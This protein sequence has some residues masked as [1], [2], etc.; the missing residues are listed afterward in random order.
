MNYKKRTYKKLTYKKRNYKKE[1]IPLAGSAVSAG[2]VAV[3]LCAGWL[4]STQLVPICCTCPWLVLLL[5]R[6]YVCCV[7]RCCGFSGFG[8][9][10]LVLLLHWCSCCVFRCGMCCWHVLLLLLF[11][12]CM[13]MLC[14]WFWH[15]CLQYMDHRLI[16]PR[17]AMLIVFII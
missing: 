10:I 16:I 5:Y 2:N 9:Y 7:C 11:I 12:T 6:L 1:L 3:E 8:F 17:L 15:F 14:L 13:Q 4:D